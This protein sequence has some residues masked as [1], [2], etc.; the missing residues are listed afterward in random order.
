[1]IRAAAVMGMA[2]SLAVLTGCEKP[3]VRL[4]PLPAEYR[5]CADEPDAPALPPVDWSSVDTARPVQRQRDERTLDYILRLRSAWG[6]C[7][8]AVAGVDA[9][10]EK[11]N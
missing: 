2:I 8:A 5:T 1:M 4:A 3:A 9:W 7:R 11:V 6:S 10:S